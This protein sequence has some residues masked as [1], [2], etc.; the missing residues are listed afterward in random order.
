MSTS[1]LYENSFFFAL[2]HLRC[3]HDFHITHNVY[4]RSRFNNRHDFFCSTCMKP[5]TQHII[6]KVQSSEHKQQRQKISAK[7]NQLDSNN[8]FDLAPS[9]V[10]ST[11]NHSTSVQASSLQSHSNG[12]YNNN[13]GNN[14]INDQQQNKYRICRDFVRGS[15]RRL[16]CKV[17][18]IKFKKNCD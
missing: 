6:T 18:L 16:F 1:Y 15:C 2:C 14:N 7:M 8:Q 3:L 4:I 9:S 10:S 5:K 13:K 12:Q 11:S 17:S